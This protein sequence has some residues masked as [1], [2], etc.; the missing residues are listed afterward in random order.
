MNLF[1]LS[2]A[3]LTELREKHNRTYY[4]LTIGFAFVLALYIVTFFLFRGFERTVYKSLA[5]MNYDF[6]TQMD[7]VSEIMS[8]SMT[9][10]AM[11]LF[12]SP[13]VQTLRSK[14]PITQSIGMQRLVD[15]K[16]IINNSDFLESVVVHNG[17]TDTVYSAGDT[18]SIDSLDDYE[19]AALKTLIIN[20]K[21]EPILTPIFCSSGDSSAGYYAIMY[22]T[23]RDSGAPAPSTLIITVNKS[24]Y[25]HNVALFSN[26]TSNLVVFDQNGT[27]L[28]SDNEEM[29]KKCLEVH[30]KMNRE[31]HGYV[32]LSGNE[33]CM[34][35][36]SIHSGLTYLR[37]VKLSESM[38][39]LYAFRNLIFIFLLSMLTVF[40]G[41]Y[42]YLVCKTCLPME[43]MEKTL[44]TLGQILE[45]KEDDQRHSKRSSAVKESADQVI[46]KV[47]RGKREHILFDILAGKLSPDRTL[48]FDDSTLS[49]A[50]FLISAPHRADVYSLTEQKV[51]EMIVCKVRNNLVCLG[52]FDSDDELS[53]LLHTTHDSLNRRLFTT[54]RFDDF[55]TVALHYN[56]LFELHELQL[57]LPDETWLIRE[58]E[59]DDKITETP[60]KTKDFTEIS[61]RLKSGNM[62][63]ATRKW[64]EMKQLLLSCR[65]EIL[66]HA[67][68]TLNNRLNKMLKECCSQEDLYQIT[69]LPEAFDSM[70]AL[71]REILRAMQTICDYY[72]Q[73]KIERYTLQSE[74]IKKIIREHFTET[75]FSSQSVA[76]IAGMNNA[77]LGRMFKESCGYSISDYIN[78]CRLEEAIK[79]LEDTNDSIEIIA[80]KAGFYN[81]K[82][83]YVLFKKEMNTTPK[84]YRKEKSNP[85]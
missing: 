70:E 1:K 55:Q 74:D 8:T 71:D 39:Q 19:N 82:Y 84:M 77:Y 78:R 53:D 64:Q 20:K 51:P 83:F 37:I 62:D 13:P 11:Q 3:T 57:T 48:I 44:N 24:W 25:S 72:S 2:K 79:L 15:L 76:D 17:Y 5:D 59:L 58:Q 12:Y 23:L 66:H 69:A 61:T 35:H 47:E 46:K 80:T 41:L 73:K 9:D 6:S 68:L 33:I 16:N 31:R 10:Y 36:T 27:V 52:L 54:N 43:K 75:D 38:T 63:S 85:A 60:F 81:V 7:A 50:M 56:N 67:L 65:Y 4:F 26:Y 49:M 40:I 30:D 42:I 34:Y 29:L 21:D 22:Y 28:L 14:N 18:N 45:V 32:Q